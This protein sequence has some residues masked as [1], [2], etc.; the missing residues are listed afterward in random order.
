MASIG[1]NKSSE[2]EVNYE[3]NIVPFIDLMSVC[4]IFLLLTAVWT[5]VSMIQLGSSVYGKRMD[6]QD[7]SKKPP[8]PEVN[9]EL[10]I[11]KRG[12]TVIVGQESPI[13]IPRIAGNDGQMEYDQRN[14]ILF[15]KVVKDKYP[16]KKDVLIALD[17]DLVYENLIQGMD[18]LL[19]AGFP[20]VAIK[21]GNAQTGSAQ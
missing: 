5:Q 18:S 16:E 19:L 14:L 1:N 6:D 7:D 12:Y 17:D 13:S 4:I 20:E 11:D 15:L 8:R 2:R 21:T 10:L 9:L 3:L